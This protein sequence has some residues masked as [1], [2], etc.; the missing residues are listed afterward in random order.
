MK[1]KKS[2]LVAL[3]HAFP[4]NFFEVYRNLLCCLHQW[5][6]NIE[7]S[8]VPYTQVGFIG[9]LRFHGSQVDTHNSV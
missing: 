4:S 5:Q 9:G 6:G 7:N 3:S 1:L 8:S 2:L